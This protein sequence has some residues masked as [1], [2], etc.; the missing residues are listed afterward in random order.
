MTKH[1]KD[2]PKETPSRRLG[3]T[4]PTPAQ[5]NF[6]AVIEAIVNDPDA[7]RWPAG[8]T[9]RMLAEDRNRLY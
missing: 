8:T 6:L 2:P 5:R 9:D 7:R 4:A 3:A 1:V